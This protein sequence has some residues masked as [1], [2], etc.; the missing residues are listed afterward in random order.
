MT[1]IRVLQDCGTRAGE[2][3]VKHIEGDIWEL[4]TLSDR[5]FFF[6]FKENTF[7]LL[8]HFVK[9]TKKTPKREIEQAKRYL[10]NYLE[11]GG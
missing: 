8:N 9:K 7:V 5:I 4:R 10:A 2:P 1:F 3:F 11:R 6:Y